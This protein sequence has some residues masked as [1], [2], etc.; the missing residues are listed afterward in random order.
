MW[1]RPYSNKKHL[2]MSIVLTL[3]DPESLKELIEHKTIFRWGHPMRI[4]EYLDMKPN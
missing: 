4:K 3:E 2:S 1:N